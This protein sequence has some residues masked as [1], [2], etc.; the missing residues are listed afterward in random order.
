MSASLKIVATKPN[1]V[2]KDRSSNGPLARQLQ[3]EWVDLRNDGTAAVSLA[4]KHLS[5]QPYDR[6]CQPKG[7]CEVYWPG[8]NL[9]L[10]P[11]QTVRIHTG[12]RADA[13]QAEPQDASG[14]NHHSYAESANF[15]L[16]ND[17]G[18]EIGVWWKDA[19]GAWVTVG[20]DSASYAPRP[21]E[22]RVLQRQGQHLV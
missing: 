21:V 1:P 9:T 3:G 22:G 8:D 19:A 7:N 5:H 4:N 17:C 18:D 10:Q 2:G 11:G 20:R 14:A 16:N 6:S 15:V 12:R 13:W